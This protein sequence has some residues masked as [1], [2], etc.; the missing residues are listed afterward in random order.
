MFR[1]TVYGLVLMFITGIVIL[2]QFV[3]LSSCANI[4]P[5]G[6]GPKDSLPP[7]IVK[8]SPGANAVNVTSNKIELEFDE[9][10][11]QFENARD[12]LLISPLPIKSPD[13]QVRL[14]SVTVKL[15]DSLEPNTTYSIDFG[16]GIKD[17]NEGNI[18]R[19]FR[20]VFSTG[21]AIDSL[22]I[23]GRV[24]LAETGKPDT[25]LIVCLYR[26]LADSAVAKEAPRYY[27]KQNGNG[28]FR[29]KNLPPGK[30]N[31]YA[32][33]DEGGQK[34]YISDKQVFAFN[35]EPVSA[36][37]EEK[38]TITLYAYAGSEEEAKPVS[39]GSSGG[40][41]RLR[42][43][44]SIESGKQDILEP[45]SFEF[46]KSLK[47]IDTTKIKFADTLNQK[48]NGYTLVIDSN[49]K[50]IS[51]VYQWKPDTDYRIIVQKD[52]ATDE[53]GNTLPRGD[54]IRFKT[55][56][57]K[58]YG[59]VKIRFAPSAL[60]TKPVLQIIQSGK[61]I[62]SIAVTN[63][64]QVDIAVFKPGEYE[65]RMLND[66]NGN[67]IWDAGS[68]FKNKKQPERV[69]LISKK[70]NVRADWENELDVE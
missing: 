64:K 18:Y 16:N 23:G 41:T 10:L 50:K 28:V 55:K 19:N 63:G 32:F 31:I 26:N 67:G 61:I 53:K 9:Y 36:V 2:Q 52:F 69:T 54:T 20:Y 14:R 62:R 1:K 15:R 49:R 30:F 22:Q 46:N 51:L 38:E 56:S 13:I 6:G 3:F 45:L 39:P 48:I 11:Q 47:T 8:M 4:I 17:V 42:V 57:Q 35:N 44:S 70:L 27:A 24:L 58:E 12:N 7:V 60:P 59:S 33:Q 65:L 29:F 43:Q 37:A 40:E 5:P 21:T 25:T 34:R 68:F 66:E